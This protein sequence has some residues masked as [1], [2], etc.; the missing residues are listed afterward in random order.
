MIIVDPVFYAVAIP[1]VLLSGISKGGFGS[2]LGGIGVPLMALAISPLQAA[3]I[4]LPV[5]CFMD[6]V[7]LRVYYKKWDSANLRI[8]LP[9][10]LLG[11]ALGTVTFGMLSENAVRILIGT[12][13]VAFTLNTWFG[14]GAR[15]SPAGR[16]LA[17][18]TFWSAVSGLTSFLAHAGG[19]PAM[20][21]MLPQRLDKT[22]YVATISLF[23][24][25]VNAVKLVP[26]AWLGQLSLANLSTSLMLAPLVPLGVWLGLWLQNRIN[27]TWFYRIAQTCLLATGLQLVYQGLGMIV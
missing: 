14:F 23:F 17:K 22:T 7:G 16:S 5:L 24:T 21:Y 27:L 8:M 9:G 26:Y 10:A 19:P 25:A 11:I 15:Q 6:L 20:V 12:I 4:L 18:G 1:A 3:A 2:A 13:A